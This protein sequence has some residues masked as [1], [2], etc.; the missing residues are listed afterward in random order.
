MISRVRTQPVRT[1]FL[2]TIQEELP[3]M[4]ERE[5]VNNRTAKKTYPS[6]KFFPQ[7]EHLDYY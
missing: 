4:G 5:I 2:K 6:Q 7:C 3:T 1:G